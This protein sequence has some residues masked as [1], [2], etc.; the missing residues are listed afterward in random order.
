[1][2]RAAFALL[3]AMAALGCAEQPLP[4]EAQPVTQAPVPDVQITQLYPNDLPGPPGPGGVAIAPAQPSERTQAVAA[5]LPLRVGP[6]VRAVGPPDEGAIA[7]N[8]L[9]QMY[10]RYTLPGHGSWATVAVN[11][12]GMEVP[13]GFASAAVAAG[14]N[15]SKASVRANAP[16]DVAR[17]R[18]VWIPD[19]PS[20]RCVTGR[21]VLQG[22]GTLHVGCSTGVA[23]QE[24]RVRATAAFRPGDSGR[25]FELEGEVA[26]LIA[27]VTRAAAGLQPSPG[28]RSDG[29]VFIPR[30]GPEAVM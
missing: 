30:F 27:E 20:Q 5:R 19:A 29:R 7:R 1:M 2:R 18:L 6:W 8:G 11:D 14:F 26:R 9:S 12:H 10:V 23:G 16:G 22:Q 4:P 15:A 13:D 21:V 28:L 25:L 24:L 17:M 3:F